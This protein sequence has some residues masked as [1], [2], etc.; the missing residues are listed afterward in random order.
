MFGNG[1]TT[2]VAAY[3]EFHEEDEERDADGHEYGEKTEECF[4]R[5]GPVVGCA[6]GGIHL[7]VC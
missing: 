2:V 4:F 6:R 3:D 7:G 1:A 5:P